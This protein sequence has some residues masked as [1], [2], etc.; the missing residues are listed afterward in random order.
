MSK[1]HGYTVAALDILD[2]DPEAMSSIYVPDA[3]HIG[4]ASGAQNL[5]VAKLAI[6]LGTWRCSVDCHVGR[7]LAAW[8]ARR[9]SSATQTGAAM[10]ICQRTRRIVK[11]CVLICLSGYIFGNDK[12]AVDRQAIN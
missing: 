2:V 8:G 3:H 1:V 12:S 4:P 10:W 6:A 9:I 7:F 5:Y 11:I